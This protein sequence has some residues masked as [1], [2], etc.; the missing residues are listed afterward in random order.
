MLPELDVFHAHSDQL[1]HPERITLHHEDFVFVSPA[2][3]RAA[4]GQQKYTIKDSV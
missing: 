3:Q 2:G 1:V 4:V